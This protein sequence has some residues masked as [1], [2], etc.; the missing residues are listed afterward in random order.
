[1]ASAYPDLASI[2]L[3]QRS[4][5]RSRARR[6][7]LAPGADR[8]LS[9]PAP[10]ERSL[11]CSRQR[12]R[13]AATRKPMPTRAAGLSL[14]VVA[15]AVTVP[16]MPAS[17]AATPAAHSAHAGASTM[18]HKGSRGR[19]VAALQR[20][21]GITA[22]GAFGP[23]TRHAVRAYQRAH[24]LEVDGVAGPETLGALGLTGSAYRSTGSA[25]SSS[26]GH[27]HRHHRSAV[28]GADR[29]LS[30]ATVRAVQQKLGISADGVFGRQT[31]HAVR[32][33]QR[34]HGLTVDGV[35]GPQ[36]LAAMGVGTSSDGSTQGERS[37]A[38][39]GSSSTDG[40]TT[41]DSSTA[42]SAQGAAAAVAAA[43]AE[44]GK[45][46]ASG[47]NGPGSFDCS[48]LTV[49]A[50]KA[51]G[52][53]LPRTSFAQYQQGSPVSSKDIQPGDLVFFDTDGPGASHVG[54]AVSS[55]SAISAT[56]HGVMEHSI[57]GGYWGDHYLG[58]R[59]VF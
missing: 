8:D 46:Y 18:L 49:W 7:G 19:A 17:A 38:T 33:Y 4:L 51:A 29:H 1:M 10:W 25:K 47:G 55:S 39:D 21:L 24:G 56:S 23:Q 28:P 35:V 32:A 30:P 54:I 53:S 11:W 22:D 34:A 42:G 15:S 40:S 6:L 48:G 5:A 44:I 27:R 9:A 13:A 45:P 57:S 59:R 41:T 20:A 2:E 36:T 50:F 37:S 26:R 14:A 58:A 31:L 3:W 52:I 16:L 12:R 43:Q